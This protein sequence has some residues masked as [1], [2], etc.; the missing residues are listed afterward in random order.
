MFD[1]KL[2]FVCYKLVTTQKL[3][4][5]FTEEIFNSKVQFLYRVECAMW[6]MWKICPKLIIK[7]PA[8]SHWH[9]SG[10]FIVNF[11]QIYLLFSLMNL[12]KQIS[13][14]Q[15][16]SARKTIEK[17]DQIFT[18]FHTQVISMSHDCQLCDW[19]FWSGRRGIATSRLNFLINFDTKIIY[20]E[21][22]L[23]N[24]FSKN[25]FLYRETPVQVYL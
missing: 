18:I 14:G 17:K 22:F 19:T 9:F 13:T 7:T 3:S 16:H 1:G 20:L 4:F 25:T 24:I 21:L 5:T 11:E 10:V 15:I 2:R 23:N 8:R 6:K 12:N